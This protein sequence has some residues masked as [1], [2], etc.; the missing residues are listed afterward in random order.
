MRYDLY[1]VT[2]QRV[3]F[4]LFVINVIIMVKIIIIGSV[5][6]SEP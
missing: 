2:R 6:Y 1:V 4:D 5:V 3:K